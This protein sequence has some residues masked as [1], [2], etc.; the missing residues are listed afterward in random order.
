MSSS[1][2]FVAQPPGHTW[3][4]ICEFII[5]EVMP[6]DLG[7][8]HVRDD[9]YSVFQDS[10]FRIATPRN[11]LGSLLNPGL[12]SA[13]LADVGIMTPSSASLQAIEGK[14]A[15]G[16]VAP[17]LRAIAAYPHDDYL[18]F[19]A[20]G[21]KATRLDEYLASGEPVSIVTGRRGPDGVAD[22]LTYCVG[23]VLARHGA[24]FQDIAARHGSRVTFGGPTRFGGRMVLDGSATALFHEA[25]GL[26]IWGDI[27]RSKVAT[28]LT[29]DPDLLPELS[30]TLGLRIRTIPAGHPAG[31]SEP[32]ATLDFSGWLLFVHEQMPF[33]VAYALA[34]ACERTAVQVA[35][36]VRE[37]TLTLPISPQYMFG[38]TELPLH[39]GAETFAK[40][41]G[42]L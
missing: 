5:S 20:T 12:V 23:E 2:T 26:Q 14:G 10:S 17:G 40:E 21:T 29:L 18:I 16:A 7:S 30:A 19:Q 41:R 9:A 4:R 24:T 35:D 1:L 34:K 37:N 38:D 6:T 22:V 27:A 25:Q 3:W 36:I 15:Y 42:Y 33:D 39:P 11:G 32:V 28:V 13:G 8:G 31:N